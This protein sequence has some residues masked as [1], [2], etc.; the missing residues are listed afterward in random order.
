MDLVGNS[1]G[2]VKVLYWEDSKDG[3]ESLI[4]DQRVVNAIDL[5]HGRL[6]EAG[7]LLHSATEQD[8]ALGVVD[9]GLDTAECSGVNDTR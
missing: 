8:L 9:L 1:N 6:N 2:L 7:L 3:T 5:N 4:N